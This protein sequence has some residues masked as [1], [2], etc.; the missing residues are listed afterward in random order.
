LAARENQGREWSINAF[1]RWWVTLIESRPRL[2]LVVIL[3][4]TIAAGFY[5]ARH[6]R[7]DADPNNLIAQNLPFQQ[8]QRA[9]NEAF[10]TFIQGLIVVIDADSPF[11][12]R[13]AADVLAERLAQRTD[14]FSQ[15]DVP[16]GGP[17]FARNALLYLER[18]Q[19]DALGDRLSAAQPFL[20]ALAKDESLAGVAGVL[21]DALKAAQEGTEIGVDLPRVLNGVSEVI[22]ATVE[23][24]AVPDP[25]SSALLGDALPAEARRRLI[26]LRPRLDY[27]DL[28]NAAPA[29]A[30]IRELAED[31]KLTPEH[32]IRVRITGDPAINYEELLAVQEQARNVAVAAFLLFGA[33]MTAALRSARILIALLGSLLVS[34]VWTNAAAAAVVGSLNQISAA[35]NVII[36]GLGGEF[37]IHFC[38]RYRELLGLGAR[39]L[40]ALVGTA[41]TIG[42]ALFSSA[43]TTAIGFSIFLFTD[44]VGVGQLG[45]ISAIGMFVS[46]ASTL[47]VLP[48]LLALGS[49]EPQVP[50]HRDHA[51]LAALEHLPLRWARPIRIGACVV[52]VAA[53]LLLPRTRYDPNLLQ[54]RDTATES[55]QAFSDLLAGS[56]TSP[57]TID[58]IAPDLD[59]AHRLAAQL[60]SLP[61]VAEARTLDSF[62][63]GD[64]EAKRAM[65]EDVSYFVPVFSEA[66]QP[67]D[68]HRQRLALERLIAAAERFAET[69]PDGPLTTA[70]ARLSRA[71][72]VFLASSPSSG[73]FER[74]NRNVL[75]SLPQQMRDLTQLLQPGVIRR[76]DLP[77]ALV[78][79]MIAS[80][81]RARVEVVPRE[82]VNDSAALERFVASVRR[83][84][85]DATGSAVWLIEWGRVT[86]QAMLR[87]L[88]GGMA[89]MVVFLLLL[90]RSWWDTLLAFF[91]LAL[92]ALLTCVSLVVLGQPFNFAN[93]I[94]IPMLI[95]M[96][97]D[98]GVH[99]VHRHRTNPEEVDLLGSSTAQAVFYAALTTMLSFGVLGLTSHR[100]MAAIGQLLAIGVAVTLFCYIVV[101]PAVLEWDDRRR[102]E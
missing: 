68:M 60:T 59:T 26:V 20:G 74:L 69:S 95:G 7:I 42:G 34:L 46:L 55:V 12:A 84:A 80:D 17:F 48:A 78:R 24:R 56:G 44:F 41:T 53:L 82:D 15:V 70:A 98:N 11:A 94:V 64:Q 52:A 21:G 32:G 89:C 14:L 83:V 25:W 1:C 13:H 35:F 28:L 90:W 5:A 45:L 58:L 16:G 33:T 54:L 102:S 29:V 37:G 66:P 87:A 85:P 71:A 30:A 39:R 88:L 50:R 31:L 47:T 19:I 10:E 101:L 100:G 61:E 51:W 65:I 81:G 62:V 97:V 43:G 3:A 23:G 76:E 27:G 93:V 49:R 67:L 2:A 9:V 63:P 79:R 18:E 86:W 38:I 75:G 91:P 92:A 36:I 72:S 4:F 22:E 6:L 96:G 57:W 77:A 40:E 99:L 73:D 8:R